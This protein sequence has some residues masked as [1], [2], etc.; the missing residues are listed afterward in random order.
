M[1]FTLSK[2][3]STKGRFKHISL[4]TLLAPNR[5]S[6]VTEL[7]LLFIIFVHTH[8]KHIGLRFSF[9]D[10]ELAIIAICL[11]EEKEAQGN[12]AGRRN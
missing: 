11:D 1:F 7:F 3:S 8:T 5:Y 12:Q 9:S 2:I 4:V 6:S 10:E